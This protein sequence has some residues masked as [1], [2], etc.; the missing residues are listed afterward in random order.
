MRARLLQ[1]L[2]LLLLC[3]GCLTPRDPVP[4]AEDP[5]IGEPGAELDARPD[6]QTDQM[7]EQ[8]GNQPAL[9]P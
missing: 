2:S 5:P 8:Q 7:R 1:V 6:I 9:L 3:G 4:S